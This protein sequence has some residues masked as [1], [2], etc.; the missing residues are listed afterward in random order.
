MMLFSLLLTY[1]SCLD[2]IGVFVGS[3]PGI[4]SRLVCIDKQLQNQ[5]QSQEKSH[6]LDERNSCLDRE[7]GGD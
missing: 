6:Q 4:Q 3:I 1:C 2:E 5:V 7:G